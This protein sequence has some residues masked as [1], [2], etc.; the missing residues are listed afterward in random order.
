[1]VKRLKD[2]WGWGEKQWPSA[3]IIFK[4]HNRDFS[5]IDGQ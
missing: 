3:R 1:M 4:I 5:R 2:R